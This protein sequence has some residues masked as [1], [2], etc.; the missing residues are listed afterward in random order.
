MG[1]FLEQGNRVLGKN[2]N[3]LLLHS[4]RKGKEIFGQICKIMARFQLKKKWL[5]LDY[6]LASGAV[7]NA[8]PPFYKNIENIVFFL[9]VQVFDNIFGGVIYLYILYTVHVLYNPCCFLNND[10]ITPVGPTYEDVIRETQ[11]NRKLLQQECEM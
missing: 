5:T 11:Q 8:L 3:Q 10:E 1:Q 4:F 2:W 6:K 9:N 7:L